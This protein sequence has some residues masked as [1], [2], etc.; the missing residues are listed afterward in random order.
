[1][2]QTQLDA[3]PVAVWPHCHPERYSWLINVGGV[4]CEATSWATDGFSKFRK[5]VKMEGMS[6]TSSTMEIEAPLVLTA[7]MHPELLVRRSVE[8]FAQIANDT[9]APPHIGL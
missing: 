3:D 2:H 4:I 5:A 6:A 8:P 7:Y 1:M 9:L